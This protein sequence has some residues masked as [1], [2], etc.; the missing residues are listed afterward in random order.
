MAT[1]WVI[2]PDALDKADYTE[3]MGEIGDKVVDVMVDLVPVNTGDLRENIRLDEVTSEHVVIVSTRPTSEQYAEE[4]PV[5]VEEGTSDTKARPYM[6][7]AL[8][9]RYYP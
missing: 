8:Y 6:R 5:Y 9:R 4:V 3:V 1:R 7:P 2:Y